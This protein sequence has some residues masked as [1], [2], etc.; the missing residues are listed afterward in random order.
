VSGAFTQATD[1]TASVPIVAGSFDLYGVTWKIEYN[2]DGGLD[3]NDVD[4][5]VTLSSV[6]EPGLLGL[7]MPLALRAGLSRRRQRDEA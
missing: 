5:D 2:V 6:P 4:N 3:P 1:G 7:V